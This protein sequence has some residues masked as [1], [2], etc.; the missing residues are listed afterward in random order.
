MSRH[1]VRDAL[2]NISAEVWSGIRKTKSQGRVPKEEAITEINVF[3][4]LFDIP[5]KLIKTVDFHKNEEGLNGADW[6]W[7]FLS[8][9]QDKSFTI[10]VQAKVLNPHDQIYHELHYRKKNGRYQSDLLIEK[11]KESNA[12]PVYCLY[13][14][15]ENIEKDDLWTCHCNYSAFDYYG[16]TLIDAVKVR[17]L[18]AGNKKSL[19]DLKSHFLPMHCAITCNMDSSLSLP[20]RVHQYW[21]VVMG[22]ELPPYKK[23]ASPKGKR[24][25]SKHFLA[26]RFEVPSDS[27]EFFMTSDPK[28]DMPSD[29]LESL[30]RAKSDVPSVSSEIPEHIRHILRGEL[31]LVDAKNLNLRATTIFFDEEAESKF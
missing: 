30:T 27:N 22:N 28:N 5:P 31:D 20:E 17:A 25:D 9:N 7:V 16:C 3:Q 23:S 29:T 24:R 4:A 2:R 26:D 14:Y 11:A 1:P 10:R 18:R 15:F 13:N 12:L 19:S 6:E 8:K 21:N